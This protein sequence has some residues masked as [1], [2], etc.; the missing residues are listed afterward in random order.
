M[1]AKK[2]LNI[3]AGQCS[4]KEYCSFDIFKKL[5]RWELEEKDIAAVMEFLVKNHFLDDTR[6]A[7]AYARDKHRFNRWGKLKIMQMLRQKRV[8]ERIIEQALS[9]LVFPEPAAAETS[10]SL[11]LKSI[12]FCCS[13]VHLTS[14]LCLPIMAL[15]YYLHRLLFALLL[16]SEYAFY[17]AH[18]PYCH[19]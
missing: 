14:I 5:Q 2:A 10:I 7:E 9:S 8:P 11:S 6:F 4:K 18:L 1:D 3:V 12:T 15:Y 16:Q 13:L 19:R 17:Q